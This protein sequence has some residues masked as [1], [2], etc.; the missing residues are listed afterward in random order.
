[1]QNINVFMRIWVL[2]QLWS[3]IYRYFYSQLIFN[4]GIK[5]AVIIN[6]F[7]FTSYNLV[8][9]VFIVVNELKFH[10]SV[11]I[12]RIKQHNKL[13]SQNKILSWLFF[14]NI[15]ANFDRRQYQT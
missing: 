5:I 10:V 4:R 14:L 6:L 12:Y 9:C 7:I 13:L 2:K 3:I 1:M 8:M 11:I 15:V